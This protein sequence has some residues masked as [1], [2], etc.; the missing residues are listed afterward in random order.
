MIGNF[1]GDAAGGVGTGLTSLSKT[2]LGLPP[3]M[4]ATMYGTLKIMQGG[5]ALLK[6]TGPTF[7][8]VYAGT[9]AGTKG[10][11]QMLGRTK[12]SFGGTMGKG[13]GVGKGGIGSKLMRGGGLLGAGIGLV[14][15]AGGLKE[16][17]A[18]KGA[19][20]TIIGTGLGFAVGG[21]VGAM[22]GGMLGGMAGGMLGDDKKAFGGGMDA[23]KINL[24][25]ENGPELVTAGAASA[26]TSNTDLAKLFN[27]Q[28]LE[29]K[30]TTMVTE[31][32]NANEKL[33]SMVNGVNT[34]VAVEGRALKAVETTARKDRNQ[35]GMIG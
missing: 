29:T 20:G 4:A 8:A 23:G 33:A 22:V 16:D 30:M 15:A 10:L 25:G 14:G 7:A 12:G 19:W 9:L 21:P 27:T 24:V 26:V 6:D 34:L 1:V 2:L 31:L 11:G 5:I 28:A 17:M 3:A 13:M 18:D 32:N 35:V